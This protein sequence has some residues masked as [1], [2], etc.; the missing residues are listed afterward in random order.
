MDWIRGGTQWFALDQ[1]NHC[2]PPGKWTGF[3]GAH[4]GLLDPKQFQRIELSA[5]P[6]AKAMTW[7]ALYVNRISAWLHHHG[8]M[9]EDDDS[10]ATWV[11]RQSLMPMARAVMR[12]F[13]AQVLL[14]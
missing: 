12:F 1:A 10:L 11:R 4:N 14:S 7:A 3:V 6:D 13:D 9:D 5:Q 2:V 8:D